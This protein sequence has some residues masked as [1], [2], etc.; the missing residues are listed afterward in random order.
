VWQGGRFE[1]VEQSPDKRIRRPWL[2][3]FPP[4][5]S[6]IRLL[7]GLSLDIAAI[8]IDQARSRWDSLPRTTR[9]DAT[10]ATLDCYN[11]PL[12][13]G[14]PPARLAQPFDVVSMQFCMHYAF[15]S[16]AKVRCM[17]TNVSR[18]LRPG[19]VFVGTVPNA[20]QLLMRLD[21]LPAD[22]PEL[23]FGNS[24]YSIKFESREPRPL[25]GHRYSFFLQDA[26]EDVPE[27]VVHWE[28]FVQ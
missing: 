7:K 3:L 9:F 10:F 21:Q 24:V 16:V 4:R 27:Y 22:A 18:W 20:E 13:R 26:V 25:Y 28:P 11:E 5:E 19:G 2:V 23:S 1:Q 17:L 14:I 12:T 15:E 6:P 8:S